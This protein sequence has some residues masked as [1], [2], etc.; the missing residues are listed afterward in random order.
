MDM[1]FLNIRLLL[2]FKLYC[3]KQGQS[4]KGDKDISVKCHNFLHVILTFT[5]FSGFPV[6]ADKINTVI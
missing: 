1:H 4:I 3:I 5:W 2:F 6:T